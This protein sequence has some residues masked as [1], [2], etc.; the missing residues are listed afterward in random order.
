MA[1]PVRTAAQLLARSTVG[2]VVRDGKET[3]RLGPRRTPAGDWRESS[4]GRAPRLGP[5]E[6]IGHDVRGSGAWEDRDPLRVPKLF[7]LGSLGG[8]LGWVTAV[9]G[10]GWLAWR[11]H[12]G[13]DALR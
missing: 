1:R 13:R 8:L 11:R 5:R 3:R 12:G 9:G 4:D 6:F 10:S 2:G 7:T